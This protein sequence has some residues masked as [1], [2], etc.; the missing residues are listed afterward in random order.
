M[1][2]QAVND[3]AHHIAS[4][5]PGDTGRSE[6]VASYFEN[7]L[8]L[9]HAHH[10]GE[11]LLL[12]PRLLQRRPEQ[13]DTITRVAA[14]HRQVDAALQRVTPLIDTWSSTPGAPSRPRAPLP[15]SPT[16]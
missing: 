5:R 11:D 10:D 8:R 9:L 3:A 2:R 15:H 7:V 12:T 1:F 16:R 6:L 4:V 14:Q 13:A